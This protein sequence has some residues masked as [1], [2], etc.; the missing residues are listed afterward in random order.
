MRIVVNEHSL[1]HHFDFIIPNS[2]L[3]SKLGIKIIYQ[4]IN[5]K[6]NITIPMEHLNTLCKS[7]NLLKEDFK[8]L[9]LVEVSTHDNDYIC[10]S[11]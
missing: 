8:G 6:E 9:T 1:N 2:L 10:I 7:L 5:R 11:L 3:F 4:I